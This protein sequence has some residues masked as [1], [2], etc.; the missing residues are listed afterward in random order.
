MLRLVVLALVACSGP[1]HYTRPA[2][3]GTIAELD[4]FVGHWHA[5]VKNPTNGK[6]FTMEYSIE[7][8][9]RGR[10]YMGTGAAAA[11][12]LEIHDLW[13]KDPVS[14][15]IIRSIFDS[16]QNVGTVR[17]RGWTGDTLVFEG[18]VATSEGNARVRE[19]IE[20]KGPDQ[21]H[22]LWE[23]KN[24]DAWV[25]YSDETLTRRR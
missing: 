9:L 14:G 2:M 24:G 13:G 1:A 22:A 10:W 3:T 21:F 12:D 8:A 11:L 5:E 23:M 20:R 6:T 25:A 18:D 15:E 7:P 16:A 19:T 17:S 4:F